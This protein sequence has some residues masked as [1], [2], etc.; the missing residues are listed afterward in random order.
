MG[1]IP[2][3]HIAER[4]WENAWKMLIWSGINETFDK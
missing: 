3:K 2:H 4:K 1:L